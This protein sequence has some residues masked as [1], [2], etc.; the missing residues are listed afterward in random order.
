MANTSQGLDIEHARDSEIAAQAY[1]TKGGDI[2]G[3]VIESEKHLTF[4]GR[5]RWPQPSMDPNDP[6]N[7]TMLEKYT[8]CLTVCF[9]TFLATVNAS[10]FTVAVRPLAKEFEESQTRIGFLVVF[11][12]LLLGLGNI[13]WIP[14]MRLV[15]KRPVFL[16]GLAILTGMNWWGYSTH[17]YNA[18]LASKI[19]SGFGAAAADATVSGLIVDLFFIHERGTSMMIFHTALSA[20][21]F[22]GPLINAY[23]VQ[24]SG[25]R[26]TCGFLGIASAV[27][28]TV[29]TFTIHET[30]YVRTKELT[31]P[32]E[33]YPPKRSWLA[34]MS[35]FRGY[36]R[37]AS[38][39][40]S[41]LT[42]LGMAAYPPVTF[43]GLAVGVFTGWNIVI[44]LT[45]S[46]T[47][48]QPPYDW[49][50]GSLGLLSIAGFIGAL[51]GFL[52]GG[53]LIDWTSRA[54]TKR[55][56]RREPE[57][58]LPAMVFP[59]FFGPMGVLVFGLCVAHKTSWV[60]PAFGYAMQGFGLTA[61]SNIAV[62]YASDSYERLAAEALVT[63]FV[64][65][66]TIGA[67]LALF[68]VNW[69]EATGLQNTFG[70][71]VAI[72]YFVLLMAIPLYFFGR[73]GAS[74]EASPIHLDP[75][76]SVSMDA[77]RGHDVAALRG[78]QQQHSTRVHFLEG[79][80]NY[81]ICCPGREP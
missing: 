38:F 81:H 75:C 6:L 53:V 48:T 18:L 69:Q 70:E 72:Q 35:I 26:W 56:G 67:I 9:F 11:N 40:K 15:G 41:F 33:S 21:F 65:R 43:T 39:F 23:I 42:V 47:F 5:S 73:R 60:G 68:I 8:T 80:E 74:D 58:R 55:N 49:K 59:A 37:D 78:T 27:T 71:M 54:M 2:A 4:D 29:G 79:L 16:A 32:V 57:Y 22:L 10:N 25:W 46:R 31:A 36:N 52:I 14:M 13:F 51:F 28:L 17:S 20:G 3:T 7:W 76:S 45:S 24:N 77:T 34:S 50:I 12:I 44:Q 61:V 1:G 64:L 62:T 19:L 30:N 63:V 66:G